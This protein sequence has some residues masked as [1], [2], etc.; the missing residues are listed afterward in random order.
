MDQHTARSQAVQTLRSRHLWQVRRF[1]AV[2]SR[3]GPRFFG[4]CIERISLRRAGRCTRCELQRSSWGQLRLVFALGVSS[5]W[6]AADRT[7]FVCS[8]CHDRLFNP[9]NRRLLQLDVFETCLA[10]RTICHADSPRP[11]KKLQAGR[12]EPVRT[13]HAERIV[14]RRII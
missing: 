14:T 12:C 11:G 8:C 5:D 13:M 9:A 3:S 7:K 4:L 6:L 1:R 2:C 10:R